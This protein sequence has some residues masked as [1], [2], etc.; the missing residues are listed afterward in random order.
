MELG[1]NGLGRVLIAD[2]DPVAADSLSEQL[3][4]EGYH[5]A[6]A[7]DGH[8][9]LAMLREAR[10]NG[11]GAYQILIADAHVPRAAGSEVLR[12]VRK[13]H[14]EVVVI[15]T[16]GYGTVEDAV[17]AVRLGAFDYLTKPVEAERL[18]QTVARAV[19]QQVLA[20]GSNGRRRAS[21]EGGLERLVG[22]DPRMH[23][24]Y[25][26]VEAVA[27]TRTTVLVNGES[28][29]GKTMIARAIHEMSPRRDGPLVTFSCGAIPETLLESELFGHVRG[30]FT[31]ADVDKPGKLRAAEGGT[32]F[33][34]EINSATP[35]LQLKLLRVLQEKTYEP[36]GSHETRTADVRFV[37]AT[38]EP[39]DRLVKEGRFREDLYYRINVVAV[40]LP[41]LRQRNGDV[42]ALAH[43][44]VNKF[45]DETGKVVT[46]I[47]AEAM[48]ALV[49]YAW[50]GNV[51]ELENAIERAVVLARHPVI[52]IEHL[53][54]P[55]RFQSPDGQP[56][57]RERRR[58]GWGPPRDWAPQA[59]KKALRE[60]EKQI[61]LA[62]LRHRHWNRQQTA[63]DL[64]IDRT[65]LYKKI[66]EYG[67]EELEHSAPA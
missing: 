21:L 22:H 66:K 34:D 6:T 64:G 58:G 29:T 26:L 37:L 3:R 51:R 54:D 24:V 63:A 65:T 8:E 46:G 55:I 56:G 9:A 16:T 11:A 61:L 13:H 15:F 32:L 45:C 40:E 20:A 28:G 35:A 23:R 59:L 7:C 60:P 10:Q 57:F 4:G 67:L 43:H 47:D 41:P 33:I 36:V 31:G 25:E 53:P 19:R 27:P 2:D 48:E 17:E 5:T 39:L 62:A 42:M 44:F 12:H 1:N 18:K 30:A 38:N 14:P 49:R 52:K 50:P